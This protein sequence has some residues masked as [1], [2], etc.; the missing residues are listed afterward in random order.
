VQFMRETMMRDSDKPFVLIRAGR[1]GFTIEPR[2]ARGWRLMLTWIA[3]S[4]LIGGAFALFASTDPEGS[5]FVVG[6]TLFVLAL[7][8][9]TIGG[10]IWMRARAE[11]VDVHELLRLKREQERKGRAR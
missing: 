3:V 11:V 9:W 5:T 10:I 4:L 2:G 6:L 1:G 8:G 7:G